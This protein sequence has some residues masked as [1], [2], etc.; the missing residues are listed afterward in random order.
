MGAALPVEGT[1]PSCSWR[2]EKKAW[3]DALVLSQSTRH[4]QVLLGWKIMVP[5]EAGPWSLLLLLEVC[6]CSMCHCSA[7]D[8]L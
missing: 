7:T 3:K 1:E 8:T 6:L 2:E 4:F 5:I